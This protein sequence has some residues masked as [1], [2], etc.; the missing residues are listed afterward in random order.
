[1]VRA[2]GRGVLTCGYSCTALRNYFKL[3]R[4]A[5][6][7]RDWE[8]WARFS[9]A[10]CTL[11]PPP[12]ERG[13]GER[14]KKGLML[15]PSYARFPILVLLLFRLCREVLYTA[16]PSI[17]CRFLLFFPIVSH[18]RVTLSFHFHQPYIFNIGVFFSPFH[19][20]A[21]LLVFLL[22]E[23]LLLFHSCLYSYFYPSFI[24][25]YCL[26]MSIPVLSPYLFHFNS[27]L[28][29]LEQFYLLIY[30]FIKNIK[31]HSKLLAIMF[32][33]L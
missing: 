31:E 30:S 10:D 27:Y 13:I 16:T 24:L 33:Y 2:P 4:M 20:R 12:A 23:A 26:C 6:G 9:L 21:V 29:L 15:F 11:S 3:W 7:E 17:L 1:M 32:H 22:L 28:S 5:E 25:V 19:S 14:E 18:S 8:V